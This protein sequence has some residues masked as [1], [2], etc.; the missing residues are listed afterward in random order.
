[1][2]NPMQTTCIFFSIFLIHQADQT[3]FLSAENANKIIQRSRRANFMIEELWQG[4]LEKE[5]YEEICSYEEARETFEDK[6][7]TGQFWST[8]Y[9]GRQCSSNPCMNNAVCADTIRSY[10]CSCPEGFKGNNCQFAMNECHLDAE[11]GCQ[12]FCEPRYGLNFYTCSCATGYRL[13]E[14]EKSCHPKDTYACGQML[15]RKT[16]S[17]LHDNHK[18]TF[19]WQVLLLNSEGT[20]YCSGVI[21][22]PSMVLTTAKCSNQHSP[23]FILLGNDTDDTQ[24]IKVASHHVHTKYSVDTGE[25]NIAMLKLQNNITFHRHTLPICIPKKDFAE[26]VLMPRVPGTVSGWQLL[27]QDDRLGLMPI[28]FSI[29]ETNK[30]TCELSLNVTQTNRMF[31]GLS[32]TN[33]DSVLADGS[34]LATE[35]NGTWFL[36]GITGLINTETRNPNVFLFTKI[37]RYLMWLD[38]DTT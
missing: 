4:N 3:V 5:C 24:K 30:G 1:M 35:H 36:T 16:L 10:T 29:T 13:G 38:Q 37:S 14:D 21:L 23:S 22:S 32:T 27:S 2:T 34:H 15:N 8:Y 11:D 6:E 28:Q 12:H 20:P 9:D 17:S 33:I 7:K 26:N 31:C 18:D 19:P 25:N